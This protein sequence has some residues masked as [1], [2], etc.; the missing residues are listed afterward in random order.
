MALTASGF[1]GRRQ[2][3]LTAATDS[4]QHNIGVQHSP[5]T[6]SPFLPTASVFS[7]LQTLAGREGEGLHCTTR[8]IGHYAWSHPWYSLEEHTASASALPKGGQA[9]SHAK[10]TIKRPE[11]SAPTAAAES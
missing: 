6:P 7:L 8:A 3:H 5:A 11:Q 1:A 4:F 9:L 2:T 10:C